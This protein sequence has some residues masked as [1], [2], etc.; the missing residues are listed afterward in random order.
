[1]ALA[2][3]LLGIVGIGLIVVRR[4]GLG[5]WS[6]GSRC[7]KSLGFGRL[8]LS[9]DRSPLFQLTYAHVALVKEPVCNSRRVP[10]L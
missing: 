3:E 7:V 6:I 5:L 9:G 10:E 1:M 8:L 4:R 2:I